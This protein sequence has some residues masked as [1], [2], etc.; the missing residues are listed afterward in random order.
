MDRS[1]AGAATNPDQEPVVMVD[2]VEA[3][4][5]QE[6]TAAEGLEGAG[7][8]DAAVARPVLPPSSQTDRCWCWF[9]RTPN[10]RRC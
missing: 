1:W 2:Q 7:G 6:E 10:S 8:G 3:E 9:R 5:A 4:T